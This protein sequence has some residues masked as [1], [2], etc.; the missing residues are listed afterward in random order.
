[1]HSLGSLRHLVDEMVAQSKRVAEYTRDRSAT[2]LH[3]ERI[4]ESFVRRIAPKSF[5]IGSGFIYGA[6]ESSK[7][8]DILVYD[9]MNF[10]PLFDEGG[11]VV[12]L[13]ESVV[14]V[15]EVK[16]SLD[17]DQLYGAIDNILSATRLNPRI[18][19]SIFSFD[20]MSRETAYG[21]IDDFIEANKKDQ[22]LI[23]LLPK[24]LVV[25]NKWVATS[26]EK[27]DAVCLV[28]PKEATFE[29][30]FLIYFSSLYYK[31]YGYRR[32]LLSE[33]RLPSLGDQGF[34]LQ[35]DPGESDMKWIGTPKALK[36]IGVTA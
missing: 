9:T 34:P 25:L 28:A 6:S 3:R 31:M 18:Q 27:G 24:S 11:Y 15:I 22:S 14:E 30:Q 13:P 10:A 2:G 17:K 32:K 21:H 1:M 29:E 36:D 23:P 20:G 35:F 16:S 33:D 26:I 8:I 4:V 12:V 5:S 7:Q 19:G